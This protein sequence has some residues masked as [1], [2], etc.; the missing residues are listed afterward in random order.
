MNVP[1]TCQQSGAT[2]EYIVHWYEGGALPLFCGTPATKRYPAMG[3]GFMYLCDE[4]SIK[5]LDYA[6]DVLNAR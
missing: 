4:H 5:H 1:D 3:G 2:C 6:E